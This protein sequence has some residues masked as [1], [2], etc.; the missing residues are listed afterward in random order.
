MILTFHILKDGAGALKLWLLIFK[1][2]PIFS[3]RFPRYF[4]ST[5]LG[6]CVCLGGGGGGEVASFFQ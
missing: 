3:K 2:T 6:V 1:A 5:I 4:G